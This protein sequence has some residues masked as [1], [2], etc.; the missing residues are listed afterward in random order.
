VVADGLNIVEPR[1]HVA[2]TLQRTDN[3]VFS[4]GLHSSIFPVDVLGD[5]RD[6][7]FTGSVRNCFFA[8]IDDVLAEVEAAE[9]DLL[10]V[11]GFVLEQPVGR[12]VVP[13]AFGG[14]VLSDPLQLVVSH[15]LVV[16]F[17]GLGTPFQHLHLTGYLK[18]L[19]AADPADGVVDVVGRQSLTRGIH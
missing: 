11:D 18:Q 1:R 16:L 5:V 17:L 3:N 8:E 13:F 12:I 7:L 6:D 4:C 2:S 9:V 10:V 15:F 19:V 14:A